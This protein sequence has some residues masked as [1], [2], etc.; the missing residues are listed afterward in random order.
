M[1]Y[2]CHL[3]DRLLAHFGVA[4]LGPIYGLLSRRFGPQGG[5][6]R[7][8]GRSGRPGSEGRTRTSVS[9]PRLVRISAQ[10]QRLKR[11]NSSGQNWVQNAEKLHTPRVILVTSPFG[12]VLSITNLVSLGVF[13]D[14]YWPVSGPILRSCWPKSF[15]QG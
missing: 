13:S 6:G 7:S 12:D 8:E 11:T 5:R 10:K 1:L 3:D 14:C 9:R 4:V 2:I 15:G